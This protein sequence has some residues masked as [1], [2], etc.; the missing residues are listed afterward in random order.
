MALLREQVV[1]EPEALGIFYQVD[2]NPSSAY[3]ERTYYT[4][5]PQE[6]QCFTMSR[7]SFSK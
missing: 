6:L 7:Q 4:K 3:R 1:S 2:Q 5:Y